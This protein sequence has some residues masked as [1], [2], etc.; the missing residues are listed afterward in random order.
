MT[1]LS[2]S[3]TSSHHHLTNILFFLG[4]FFMFHHHLSAKCRKITCCPLC[5]D[6]LCR[7]CTSP[8]FFKYLI[9]SKDYFIMKGFTDKDSVLVI[10][11]ANNL[12]YMSQTFNLVIPALQ[13]TPHHNFGSFVA[14]SKR[15]DTLLFEV[16]MKWI[17]L[18]KNSIGHWAQLPSYPTPLCPRWIEKL[19]W[20]QFQMLAT[21]SSL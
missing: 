11:F 7:V 3:L 21:D 19:P 13:F 18:F 20:E 15:V 1:I 10:I 2:N 5:V 6:P 4:V 14:P 8:L 17:F 12:I 9:T 16:N